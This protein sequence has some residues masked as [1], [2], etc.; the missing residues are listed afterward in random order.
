MLIVSNLVT[1]KKSM[2]IPSVAT[3]L[4]GVGCALLS[5]VFKKREIAILI[6]T[7]FCILAFTYYAFTGAAA[8]TGIL[9]SFLLPIGL[10]YFVSVK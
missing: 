3:F 1:A 8:G 9:W 10:S 5:G 7:A 4:G 6:P 2:L